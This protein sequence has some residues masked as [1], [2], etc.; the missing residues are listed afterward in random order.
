MS[1]DEEVQ[2]RTAVM[3]ITGDNRGL[4][5]P[6]SFDAIRSESLPLA[7]S[8]VNS[9]DQSHIIRVFL[10]VAVQFVAKLQK[11]EETLVSIA[12]DDDGDTIAAS[13]F[14]GDFTAVECADAYVDG[15]LNQSAKASPHQLEIRVALESIERKERGEDS[16][17]AEFEHWS[18]RW[19]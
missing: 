18:P 1:L 6:I 5:T 14:D 15:I 13:K 10:K 4:S 16:Y 12:A 2:R 3:I 17:A 7:R 11:R 19:V 8:D 9:A